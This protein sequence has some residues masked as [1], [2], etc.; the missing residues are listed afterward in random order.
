M[1]LKLAISIEEL[2]NSFV[3]KDCTG[4]FSFENK[5]GYGVPNY[6]YE[7]I[8]DAFIEIYSP[9]CNGVA[10]K[11]NTLPDF[12]NKDEF[13]YEILPYMV[14]SKHNEIES[15]LWKV[16]QTVIFNK[17]DG[18]LDKQTTLGIIVMKNSIE[19]CIDKLTANKLT[20][21]VFKDDKQKL[22]IELSNLLEDVKLQI[23][24]GLNDLANTTI[25]YLKS[26]CKCCGCH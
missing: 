20:H 3:I 16:R 21:D 9:S 4:K 24:R 6:K 10:I 2:Q 22:I 11:I 17:K 25:E 23:E 26:H 15:G 13:D 8:N 18:S 7:D 1:S 12:P 14:G 5:T 19:C